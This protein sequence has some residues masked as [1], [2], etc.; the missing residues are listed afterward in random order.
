VPAEQALVMSDGNAKPFRSSASRF[1]RSSRAQPPLRGGRRVQLRVSVSLWLVRTGALLD[2]RDAAP[3][4]KIVRKE[5]VVL[6]PT[7][8][9]ATI[10]RRW[11]IMEIPH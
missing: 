9:T 7:S 3:G 2:D 8:G 1:R 5:F 11:F 6:E 4:A 10:G